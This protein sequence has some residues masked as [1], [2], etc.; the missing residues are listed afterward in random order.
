[1]GAVS[2][3]LAFAEATF[4]QKALRRAAATGPGSWLFAR[5]LDHID[6]PVHR[7]SGGRHTLVSLLSGLPV[8]MLTSTG[9]RSGQRRTVPLVGI[10]T[11]RG[12][13]II[14]SNYGQR[15]HPAWYH[16]LRA[17]PAAEIVIRGDRVPVHAITL[18]G[19]R[20]AAVWQDAL[21]IYPGF[22]QY[23]RRAAHRE[24]AIF[25]LEPLARAGGA[26]VDVA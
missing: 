15:R 24:I 1:M 21:R 3:G 22:A 16:N 12:V 26:G 20:R 4:V 5:V 10:P 18:E 14:S 8:V 23:E 6:R 17:N 11:E 7:L 9:A 19:E 2:E 25:E 13:A